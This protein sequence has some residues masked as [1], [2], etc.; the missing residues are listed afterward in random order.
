MSHDPAN[1]QLSSEPA[2]TVENGQA[3]SLRSGDLFGTVCGECRFFLPHRDTHTN[4]IH[5]SKRGACGWK[6]P[7]HKWPMAYRKAAH[8]FREED[9]RGPY[10]MPVWKH[11]NA[12]TC[13]CFLP[14]VASE[15]RPGGSA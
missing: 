3:G 14:N 7:K 15:P 11:T 1:F 13:A 6:P 4:R 5:P 10:P 12:K 8:S 2:E 9:P